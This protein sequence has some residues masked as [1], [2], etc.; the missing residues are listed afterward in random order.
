MEGVGQGS[1]HWGVQATAQ[2]GVGG[3]QNR[4][5][6]KCLGCDLRTADRAVEER[7]EG[8]D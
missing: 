2:P 7:T 8:C 6:H 1:K 3:E 4:P 5:Q